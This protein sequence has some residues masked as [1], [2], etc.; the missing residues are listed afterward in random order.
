MEMSGGLVVKT[1][2]LGKHSSG[3]TRTRKQLFVY[4]VSDVYGIDR[5][6]V[7]VASTYRLQ[8]SWLCGG[9]GGKRFRRAGAA[10]ALHV[11]G[12]NTAKNNQDSGPS[13]QLNM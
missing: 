10:L 6:S 4:S 3:K 11:V 1:T 13:P 12:S 2:R 7:V 5:C 9:S 8:N